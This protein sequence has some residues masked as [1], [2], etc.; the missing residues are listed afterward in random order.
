[1]GLHPKIKW[2]VKLDNLDGLFGV[3]AATVI[4]R[5]VQ[6]AL[7][8]IG[9]HARAKKVSLAAKRES[10]GISITIED[11]GRGF[12]ATKVLDEKKSLGLLAMEER[13]KILGGSFTLW[14]QKNR[15]TKISL[16]VPFPVREG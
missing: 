6:E 12:E 5:V 14:S 1:M 13:I 4:Y 16:T 2:T 9:K 11:D 10:K 3:P 8:N 15:G 7:T